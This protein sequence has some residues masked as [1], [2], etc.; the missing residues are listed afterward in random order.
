M[1]KARI[2]SAVLSGVLALGLLTSCNTVKEGSS[3]NTAASNEDENSAS[4]D[5]DDTE[6]TEKINLEFSIWSDEENYISKVV[7]QYNASQNKIHINLTSVPNDSYDDRLKV[8]ISGGAELDIVDIRGM[9]QVTMYANTDSLLDITDRIEESDLDVSKYGTMW[10][11]S[12]NDGRFFALPTRTTCW[13]LFYNKD[14]FDQAEMNYPIDITWDE[15]IEIASE[16]TEKLK[17]TPAEDGSKIYGGFWVPWIYQFQA[18]QEGFYCDSDD[19]DPLKR[20]LET[21]NTIWSNGSH[22]SFAETSSGDY[23]YMS[24]FQ[25]GHAA[26]L[27]NGEW[28][29]NMILQDMESGATDV[30]WEVAAM[31]IPKGAEPGTTWGQFQ[32]AA[33]T[34]S[35]KHPDEAF[36]FISYLCGSEGSEI[37]SACGMIHAYSSAESAEVYKSTTGKDSVTVFF[38]AKKLQEQPNTPNYDKVVTAFTENAQLYFLGEKNIDETME[39]FEAQRETALE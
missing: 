1:K 33:I 18:I 5:K 35:S 8:M 22:L 23:D 31:P 26:M 21:L 13:A 6:L 37:Y 34:A 20:S 9:A 10:N 19:T 39:N 16:I 24:E 7:E 29:V 11:N 25:N 12:S 36:D 2:F 28:V 27:P 4:G 32:F 30:N 14:I 17:D 15:Y 3:D 38:D